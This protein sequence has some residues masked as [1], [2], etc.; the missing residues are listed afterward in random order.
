MAYTSNAH[1]QACHHQTTYRAEVVD[2][3]SSTGRTQ[4]P[5]RPYKAMRSTPSDMMPSRKAWDNAVGCVAALESPRRRRLVSTHTGQLTTMWE[6][7]VGHSSDQWSLMDQ[8]RSAPRA[9]IK[10]HPLVGAKEELFLGDHEIEG[11]LNLRRGRV[12]KPHSWPRQV[13]R[14]P[15]NTDE[16]LNTEDLMVGITTI[17][18]PDP[19]PTSITQVPAQATLRI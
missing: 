2:R 1:P 10:A 19:M 4:I 16:A 8:V 13:C 17:V 15:T 18:H 7:W 3:V 14:D 9:S 5:S 11:W 12:R 6:I